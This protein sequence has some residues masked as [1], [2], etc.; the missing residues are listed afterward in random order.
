M[1]S[2]EGSSGNWL[3]PWGIHKKTTDAEQNPTNEISRQT[4]AFVCTQKHKTSKA[5]FS[6]SAVRRM[7]WLR[8]ERKNLII[9]WLFG[10]LTVNRR[11]SSQIIRRSLN[12]SFQR[13]FFRLDFS[14]SHFFLPSPL[15]NILRIIAF[16]S[17]SL[18]FCNGNKSKKFQFSCHCARALAIF[19]HSSFFHSEKDF[20]FFFGARDEFQWLSEPA[21]HDRFCDPTTLAGCW[22]FHLY[23][24]R[25]FRSFRRSWELSWGK[26]LFRRDKKNHSLI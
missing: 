14:F 21:L 1:C 25:T 24:T 7:F 5:Q 2:L 13:F 11:F 4:L 10:L 9:V 19:H 3:Y 12:I 15:L 8:P 22:I 18:S 23:A 17:F 16:F 6:H 20:S 26:L